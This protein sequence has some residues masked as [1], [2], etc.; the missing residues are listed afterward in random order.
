MSL[1]RYLPVASK[2][3]APIV[4][5]SLENR[6]GQVGFGAPWQP[7]DPD[8]FDKLLPKTTSAF[9]PEDPSKQRAKEEYRR[10]FGV[11][12]MIEGRRELLLRQLR[13]V[14]LDREVFRGK[15]TKAKRRSLN[16]LM[17][18]IEACLRGEEYELER[19]QRD[20]LLPL[21][22]PPEEAYDRK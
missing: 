8:S 5:D 7:L 22:R 18:R 1:S 19:I 13:E 15:V 16:V 10:V 11:L 12:N 3:A 20:G 4:P 21:F 14:I 6:Y 17:L 2:P 9:L